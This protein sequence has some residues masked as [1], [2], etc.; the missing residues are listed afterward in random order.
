MNTTEQTVTTKTYAET[1][2]AMI[3]KSAA[4]ISDARREGRMSEA[5]V[6]EHREALLAMMRE[7]NRITGKA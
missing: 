1:L 6:P 4:E 2:K 7:H 5:E 3:F